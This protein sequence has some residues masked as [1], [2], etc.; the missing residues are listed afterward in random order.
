MTPQE[1]LNQKL[2]NAP[3]YLVIEVLD[4]LRFLKAKQIQVDQPLAKVRTALSSPYSAKLVTPV[5]LEEGTACSEPDLSQVSNFPS[6]ETASYRYDD[7]FAPVV[8]PESWDA[9]Q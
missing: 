1:K 2:E 6:S 8:S 9:L 7:P 3:E 4:F 5:S